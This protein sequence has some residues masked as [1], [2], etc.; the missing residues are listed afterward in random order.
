MKIRFFQISVVFVLTFSLVAEEGS[1]IYENKKKLLLGKI[2]SSEAKKESFLK[3]WKK[4]HLGIK[5]I[6][7]GGKIPKIIHQIWLGGSLPEKFQWMADSWRVNHSDWKYKL[8]T[9]ADIKNFNLKNYKKFSE[10]QNY[11]A[12]A[13]IF[14]YEIL[15]RYGGVY[16]DIDYECLKPIDVIHESGCSF[17]SCVMLP[18]TITNAFIG[19]VPHHPIIKKCIEGVQSANLQFSS[20]QDVIEALGPGFFTKK[21]IEYLL[22]EEPKEKIYLFDTDFCFPMPA[23]RRQIY[24]QKKMSNKE[25]DCYRNKGSFAI[26]YWAT[27]WQK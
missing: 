20:Y 22:I 14:R 2:L 8:W 5:P 11:G 7:K 26:H 12:K 13:D 3:F 24:W 21:I 16:I 27:S 19:C 25:L 10:V 4:D 18:G 23:S 17:Y 9:D 15:E 6:E 1:T